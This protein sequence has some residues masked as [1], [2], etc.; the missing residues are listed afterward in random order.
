MT[1]P[2]ESST[3]R[4]GIAGTGS[5]A[6][7]FVEGL[8]RVDDAAAVAVGSNA[9]R[10]AGFAAEH[11]I[12]AA[13]ESYEALAEADIDVV[14]IASTQER[15]VD[16][17]LLFV[18]AGVPVLCEKP[19]ALSLADAERMI[20]AAREH[21]VFVM[22]A[23]WSRFQPSYHA[24]EEMLADGVI[25]EPQLV[26]ADFGLFV[27]DAQAE[28]HRLFDPGRGGGAL[29]DLGVYPVQL[30][31]LVLGEPSTIASTGR[32]MPSGIDEHVSMVLGY[33]NGASALLYAGIRT[34]GTCAARIAGTEGVIEL[35]PF[36]HATS[37]IRV[38]RGDGPW[39]PHTYPSASLHYP[40]PAVHE[41]LRAGAIES[42]R[43]PHAETLAIMRTLDTIVSQVGIRFGA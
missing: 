18:G 8:D 7:Q 24:L 2:L 20:A 31:H 43:M 5:I 16:D 40:V 29:L 9:G 30:A 21:G 13:Y 34:R 27:P 14:Y 28:G 15:H 32:L 38:Q 36:F 10:A 19:F 23:L 41:A 17:V 3:I 35:D 39:E 4:W 1:A 22:E 33:D 11:G 42:Q 37:Q 26:L 12:D 25:G 6:R